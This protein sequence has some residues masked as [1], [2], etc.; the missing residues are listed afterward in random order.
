[1]VISFTVNTLWDVEKIK[2]TNWGRIWSSFDFIV[3]AEKCYVD[4]DTNDGSVNKVDE[5]KQI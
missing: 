4:Y 1:M 2:R 5:E 3:R